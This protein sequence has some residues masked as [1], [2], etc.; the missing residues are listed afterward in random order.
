MG[1][2]LFHIH[3]LSGTCVRSIVKIYASANL[4]GHGIL[5]DEAFGDPCSVKRQQIRKEIQQ[6]IDQDIKPSQNLTKHGGFSSLSAG[7][8]P[9]KGVTPPI[10]LQSNPFA[11][12]HFV[13]ESNAAPFKGPGPP[14]PKR[15]VPNHAVGKID[16]T[17]KNECVAS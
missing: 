1:K 9:A 12:D 8:K 6:N 11:H 15:S 4:N 5:C 16:F 2:A 14:A 3:I 17:C 10:F 7:H 13:G